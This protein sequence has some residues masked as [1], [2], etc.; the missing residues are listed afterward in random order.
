MSQE[1]LVGAEREGVCVL[2]DHEIRGDLMW[3][4]LIGTACMSD[5]AGCQKEYPSSR[6][7]LIAPSGEKEAI[8]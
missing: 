5:K 7:V 2:P 6:D 4:L 1:S 3:T 8:V